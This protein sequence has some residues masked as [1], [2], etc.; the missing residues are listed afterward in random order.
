MK[1]AFVIGLLTLIV[2]PANA[3]DPQESAAVYVPSSV[4]VRLVNKGLFPVHLEIAGNFISVGSFSHSVVG[5][6]AGTEVRLRS[7]RGI[8]KVLHVIKVSDR[9]RDLR[10]G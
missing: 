4:S 3:R 1:R 9:N 8:G 2:Y 5:F 6:P 10:V 7:R